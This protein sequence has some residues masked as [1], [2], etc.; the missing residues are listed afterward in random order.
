MNVLVTGAT[1]SSAGRSSRG[2]PRRPPSAVS[3]SFGPARAGSAGDADRGRSAS[4]ATRRRDPRGRRRRRPPRGQ[5]A[6]R[7]RRD[8]PPARAGPPP[9]RRDRA[10]ARSC[11]APRCARLRARVDGLRVWAL[12]ERFAAHFGAPPRIETATD[13]AYSFAISNSL[14]DERYPETAPDAVGRG[15]AADLARLIGSAGLAAPSRA[16]RRVPSSLMPACCDLG[17]DRA[18]TGAGQISVTSMRDLLAGRAGD[19]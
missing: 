16:E 7:G 3:R 11:A 14:V 19:A 4:R 1:V 18:Q 8:E 6:A 5:P 13:P 12:I 15:H 2:S 9:H 10:P 17:Q